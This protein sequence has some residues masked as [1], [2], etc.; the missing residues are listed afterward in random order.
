MSLYT[1][2]YFDR[3]RVL[4]GQ[5]VLNTSDV[6]HERA[7]SL[8]SR[9]LPLQGRLH[10]HL[11][12]QL[13]QAHGPAPDALVS[14]LCA[15]QDQGLRAGSPPSSLRSLG[16]RFCFFDLGDGRHAGVGVWGR[17]DDGAGYYFV[18]ARANKR[19]HHHR[20]RAIYSS[21][22]FVCDRRRLNQERS[23]CSRW[24]RE[25]QSHRLGSRRGTT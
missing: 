13:R 12:R 24:Q 7:G 4:F 9:R 21:I 20:A 1:R 15:A 16:W 18:S 23:D 5:A 2:I 17:A 22:A 14:A 6:T 11:K 19:Q 8:A 10:L 3:Q 25:A